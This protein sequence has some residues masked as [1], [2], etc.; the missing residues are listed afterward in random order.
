MLLALS[1]LKILWM[2][3]SHTARG[4]ESKTFQD[5]LGA[6]ASKTEICP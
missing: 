1:R 2:A 5:Y 6:A 3:Y 4:T